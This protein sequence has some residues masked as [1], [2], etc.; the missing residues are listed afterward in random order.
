MT[1]T[2]EEVL[3]VAHLS[4]LA[5]NDT[6]ISVMR[7]ELAKILDYMNIL[8]GWKQESGVSP[9]ASPTPVCPMRPDEVAPSAVREALLSQAPVRREDSVI[10]PRTV[11]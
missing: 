6:E 3:H 1:V 2:K 5:L 10:V 8:D 9:D 11:E 4:R 7:E